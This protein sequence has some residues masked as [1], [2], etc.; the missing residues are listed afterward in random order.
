MLPQ[1]ARGGLISGSEMPGR[2]SLLGLLIYYASGGQ[3]PGGQL[4]EYRRGELA[5]AS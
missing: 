2:H 4:A 3:A 1:E 5:A